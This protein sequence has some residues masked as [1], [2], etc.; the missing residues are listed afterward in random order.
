M[1]SSLLV[2]FPST[3]NIGSYISSNPRLKK[4]AG[5]EYMYVVKGCPMIIF[6]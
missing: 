2:R 6:I 3:D 4:K 1:D 5:I